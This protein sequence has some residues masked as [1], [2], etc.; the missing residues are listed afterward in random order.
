MSYSWTL[1]SPTIT[2]Q[3]IGIALDEKRLQLG[4]DIFFD[5]DF[6]V[7]AHGDYILLEG[8][9]AVRQSIYR[10]LLTRPGEFRARPEYGVGV[11]SFVKK[12]RTPAAMSEL[13][14]RI[15]DQLSFDPRIASIA[16]VAVEDIDGGIKISIAI[17]IAGKTLRFKPFDFRETVLIGTIATRE[18]K[19]FQVGG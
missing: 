3:D 9:E 10:R 8:E 12:R 6:H 16:D 15:V 11:L 18:G 13:R 17:E 4:K 14:Q 5:G 7:A 2:S 1:P 19:S